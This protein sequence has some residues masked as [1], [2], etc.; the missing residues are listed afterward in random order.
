MKN[1]NILDG[2][3]L[4]DT[5][6]IVLSD[7]TLAEMDLS[8]QVDVAG[9]GDNWF[10]GGTNGECNNTWFCGD[11]SNATCSNTDRC[12]GASNLQCGPPTTT[13]PGPGG[14]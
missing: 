6:R 11:S 8:L 4:D 9:G 13:D 14:A 12:S 3:R 1:G 7:E 2:M 10:C 5:G